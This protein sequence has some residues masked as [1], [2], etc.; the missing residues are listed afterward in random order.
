MAG[1]FGLLFYDVTGV[2]FWIIYGLCGISDI[3]D[4][5]LARKLKCVSRTGVLLE[6]W[7]TSASLRVVPGNSCRYSNCR[8][9]YGC[10][11]E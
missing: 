10:G 7:R 9:G 4:G 5:W 6:A 11:L 8:N 1:S 3:A 2:V